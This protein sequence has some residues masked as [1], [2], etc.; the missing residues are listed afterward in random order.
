MSQSGSAAP[1]SKADAAVGG[2]R[3]DVPGLLTVV[4]GAATSGAQLIPG[5]Q[6]TATAT[7]TLGRLALAG[8]VVELEGLQWRATEASGATKASEAG[9]TLG[10]V[11]VGGQRMPVTDTASLAHALDAANK[12]L[13]PIG[14]AVHAPTVQPTQTGSYVTPLRLSINST[15]Q[16]RALLA[17]SLDAVQPVRSQLLELVSPLAMSP[18]CGMAKALGFGYLIADLALIVMGDGGGLDLG[19]ARAGTDA[20]AY[21]NPLDSRFGSIVPPGLPVVP[22]VPAQAQTTP[23]G[24]AAAVPPTAP[25]PAPQALDVAAPTTVVPV[26]AVCRSTHTDEGCAGR[27]GLLAAWLALA[28]VLVLAAADWLRRRA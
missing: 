11:V 10:A 23:L 5:K 16:L 14:L 19:R 17:P 4:G 3:L 13:E 7:S 21:A 22:P 6:R 27:N 8:G 26:A 25:A 2:V 20:T 24:P 12:A 28:V 1:H 9:F 18:D 15:P